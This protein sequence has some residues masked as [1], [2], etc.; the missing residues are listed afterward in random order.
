MKFLFTIPEG[1]KVTE[2]VFGRVLISSVC[3]ILLCMACL[4]GTTWAWF[5]ASVVNNDNVISIWEPTVEVTL[6]EQTTALTTEEVEP[7]EGA[8]ASEEVV[9]P[10]AAKI[11]QLDL[12]SGG[13]VGVRVTHSNTPDA[14][15]KQSVLYVTFYVGDMPIGYVKLGTAAEIAF[16]AAADCTVTWAVTWVAPENVGEIAGPVEISADMIA[17]SEEPPSNE[18]PSEEPPTNEPPT[19]EP[20]SEEPPTNEPPSEEPPSNEDPSNEDP[21][22]EDPSNE[23]PSNEDPSGDGTLPEVTTPPENTETT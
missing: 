4:A 17:V 23:D 8:E 12:K 22:N 1:A 7:S 9:A 16:V 19:N 11:T 10:E 21:S 20:P 13:Q 5:Q 6:I 18:P 15:G 3:S 2:K 14:L